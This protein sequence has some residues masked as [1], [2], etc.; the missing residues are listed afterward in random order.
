MPRINLIQEFLEVTP[1]SRIR[2]NHG[3]EH[4]ALH[5]LSKKYPRRNMAGHSDVNGFWLIGDL[6]SE[7]VRA[8]I[9]E[10]LERMRAGEEH[11]AVHPNCGTNFVTSGT[12][13]GLG[14]FI[15]LMGAGQRP[16]DKMERLPLAA[17][18][19]TLALIVAQPLGLF[20]QKEVTTSGRPKTLEVT[21]I[22]P[23]RRGRLNAHRV[24]TQG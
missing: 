19:A 18:L 6:P 12:L 21:E 15:A 17:T 10:A 24:L 20:M 13:A 5:I 16:R 23:T 3:L 9:D 8:A 14:A 22:I 2:R 1:I 11:L 4:A 7:D